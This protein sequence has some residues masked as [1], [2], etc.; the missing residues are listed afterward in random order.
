MKT[1]VKFN[2][3]RFNSHLMPNFALALLDWIAYSF[4]NQ[5]LLSTKSFTFMDYHSN[6]SFFPPGKSILITAYHLISC[7]F[8]VHSFSD[9]DLDT[10]TLVYVC[11]ISY[12]YIV[13]LS[14]N[15][16][17]TTNRLSL[18]STPYFISYMIATASTTH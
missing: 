2:H 14:L 15:N 8:K 9:H 4:L 6:L 5:L 18:R 11:Q 12:T 7:S 10:I 16:R 13:L 3:Y 1:C 17:I